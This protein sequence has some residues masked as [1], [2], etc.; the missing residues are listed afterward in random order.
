MPSST[1][2]LEATEPEPEPFQC[3]WLTLGVVHDAGDWHQLGDARA[4]IAAAICAAAAHDSLRDHAQSE[5]CVALSDDTHV[6]RLNASYRGKDKPTNVLSF[7]ADPGSQDPASS[8]VF[9]GDVVLALETACM[10]AA[11]L[12]IP[13]LH[14][15]QHL[16]VHGVL[17]LCGYDH[18]T[19]DDAVIMECLEIEILGKLGVAN[20]YEHEADAAGVRSKREAAADA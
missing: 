13:V 17:H 8:Q 9:L 15:V 6:Q 19:D 1:E 5:V 3:G 18:E 11:G 10:E 12:G 16:A 7:P 2:L 20:P 14:H 4:A